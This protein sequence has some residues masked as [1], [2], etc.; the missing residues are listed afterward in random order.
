MEMIRDGID[1]INNRT[2]RDVQ[3]FAKTRIYASKENIEKLKQNEKSYR[4]EM[5]ETYMNY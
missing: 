4:E 3:Y 1:D 2:I 5:E